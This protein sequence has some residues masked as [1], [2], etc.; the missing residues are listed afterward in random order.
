MPRIEAPKYSSR[1]DQRLTIEQPGSGGVNLKDLEYEQNVNQSPFM[2]NMMYRNGAFSKRYGQEMAYQ[3]EDIY[4]ITSYMGD[5]IVHAADKLYR[6]EGDSSPVDMG[7]TVSEEK[8]FFF[9]FTQNLFYLQPSGFH[10][11]DGSWSE[12]DPYVPDVVINRKPDGSY[13][14]TIDNFNLLTGK[15]ANT[16]HGDGTSTVYH[17]T[18]TDLGSYI[19]VE[20][21]LVEQ[22]S[23]F[24]FDPVAG[25]VT[26]TTA[27]AEG[28]N[29]VRIT[30]EKDAPEDRAKIMRCKYH[31]IFGGSN[32]SRLFL[33]GGGDSYYYWSDVFDASYFPD[34]N[35]ASLGNDED[36]I[37]GFGAQ[38][39]VLIVFK[40]K[41]IYSLTY[42]VQSSSTTT[43]SSEYGVG[44]FRSQLVNDKMGCDCPGSIQLINNQLTWLSSTDGVCTLV[45]TN[46]VDERNVRRISRNINNSNGLGITGLLEWADITD[47]VS[48]DFE[49]K[50]ILASPN[51]GLAY[52]WDYGMSPYANTGRIDDDAKRLAWFPFTNI[53]ASQFLAL[54]GNLYYTR[55]G[56]IARFNY[57][58]SDFGNSISA[59]Y[60][61]PLMQFGAME[62][63]KNVKNMYVQC[64]ADTSSVIDITYITERTPNGEADDSIVI[65]AQ[66][67]KSFNYSMFSYAV[68]YFGNAFRR[69]CNLWKVQMAGAKF[70]NDQ[71]GRD[72]SISSLAFSY[73]VIRPVR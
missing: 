47:A 15:F 35:Y 25:T 49:N 17:L 64:R 62:Y 53:Y 69:R 50:Y 68:L 28:T 34:N 30:V 56:G 45:S 63:L 60:Q 58:Y 42:F 39:N 61:T 32:N 18:D 24:T 36:D 8:G 48:V 43:D 73:S 66:L 10:V 21:D 65:G 57:S 46:I 5:I 52:V 38:Y 41:E 11:Y 70:S 16:F 44:A 9:N 14:D 71:D 72:M 40:P 2:K 67:W 20:F 54:N 1:G 6:I 31:A 55:E 23:G 37:T 7:V 12:V 27:P 13:S 4:A 33:A 51:T 59:V 19:K 29:N 22:T 3:M 26:F